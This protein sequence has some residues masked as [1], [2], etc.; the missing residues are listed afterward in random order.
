[1]I[2]ESVALDGVVL[3]VDVLFGGPNVG[4]E[5]FKLVVPCGE[6]FDLLRCKYGAVPQ[7]LAES[8]HGA[9]LRLAHNR[10][11]Y[12]GVVFEAVGDA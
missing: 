8:L 3:K 10:F 4:K 2:A 6:Y 5:G 12:D 9:I 1:M 11:A 7:A